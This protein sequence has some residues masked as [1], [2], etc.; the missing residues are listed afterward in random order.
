VRLAIISGASRGLGA[1]LLDECRDQFDRTVAIVRTPLEAAADGRIE[2]VVADL[3]E[4]DDE[5]EAGLERAVPREAGHVVFFSNAATIGPIATAAT[6]SP[7]ALAEVAQVNLVAPARI[8]AWLIR[9]FEADLRRLTIVDVSSGAAL[10]P[11]AG[12]SAYCSTKAAARMYF[13]CIAV[14]H[15]E[16]RVVHFDPG[17]MNTGMQAQIRAGDESMMP[18]VG[19]F[20]ELHESGALANPAGVARRLLAEIGAA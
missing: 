10:R 8:S 11:I 19:A 4:A 2:Q 16:L 5:L 7:A 6:L 14:D 17:V 15:P 20:R 3:A 13:A 9:R 1:A 12:W 18:D